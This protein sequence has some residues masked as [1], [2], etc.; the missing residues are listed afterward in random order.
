MTIDTVT[1]WC[2]QKK[3]VK[4]ITFINLLQNIGT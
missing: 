2:K 3:T 1:Q 4:Y